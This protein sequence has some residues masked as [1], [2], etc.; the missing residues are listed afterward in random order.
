MSTY[1]RTW[2]KDIYTRVHIADADDFV[3]V[4]IVVTAYT[5]KFVSEGYVDST[6]GILNDFSH[7]CSTDISNN[8]IPLTEVCIILLNLL[9]NLAR[10]CTNS[11]IVVEKF[12]NHIARNNTFRSVYEI[13]ILTDFE[14]VFLNNWAYIAVN[15]TRANS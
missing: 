1:T 3:D 11:A 4:H 13:N 2:L 10:V 14:P 7:L 5:C 8:D 15:G 12:V 9:T 6:E